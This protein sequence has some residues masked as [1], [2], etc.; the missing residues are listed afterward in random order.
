MHKCARLGRSGRML[1]QEIC[2]KDSDDLRLLNSEAIL[3]QKQ[4]HSSYMHMAR[5]VLAS[6]I[7]ICLRQL[8]SNF[9]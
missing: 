4:S 8:K 7:R 3:G 6:H 5:R 2:E 1:P 9:H